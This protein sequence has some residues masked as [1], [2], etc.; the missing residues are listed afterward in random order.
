MIATV[1]SAIDDQE[2]SGCAADKAIE[3]ARVSSSKL[4][5]FM[6]NPVILPG[7]GPVAYRWT[8]EYIDEYFDLA[9][10]RARRSGVFDTECVTKNTVDIASAIFI[11]AENAKADYIVVGSNCRSGLFGSWRHSITRIVSIKAHCPTIIVHQNEH[12]WH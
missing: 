9:R 8:K 6:A 4:I 10:S 5:F 7:R 3:I 12:H 11:Q 1:F 2:H